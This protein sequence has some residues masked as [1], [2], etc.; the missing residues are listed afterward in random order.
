VVQF[1]SILTKA[2]HQVHVFVQSSLPAPF[3]VERIVVVMLTQSL[4][5]KVVA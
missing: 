3:D 1:H 4:E 5:P 2:E